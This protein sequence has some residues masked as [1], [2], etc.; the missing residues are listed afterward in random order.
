MVFEQQSACC[1]HHLNKHYLYDIAK[2]WALHQ[3]SEGP[4]STVR[5]EQTKLVNGF[6]TMIQKLDQ[7]GSAFLDI[8]PGQDSSSKGDVVMSKPK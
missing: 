7:M 2:P 8:S 6:H 3:V 4:F 5:M 1:A